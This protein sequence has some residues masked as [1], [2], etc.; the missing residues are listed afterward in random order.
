MTIEE[1]S[2]PTKRR[3]NRAVVQPI[4]LQERDLDMLLS[5]SIGRYLP[6]P[7]IEWLH[8][9][10]WRG[11]Y[12]AYL[13]Q[14]ETDAAATF[15]PTPKLYK[16]LRAMREGSMP[17]VNRLVRSVERATVVFNRLPDAYALTEA[18][19]EL[20]CMRRGYEMDELWYEDPRKRS[21][22]NFEH[23]VA[24]GT[25]Y[26]ALRSTLEFFGQELTDWRGDHLLASRDPNGKGPNYDRVR[27]SWRGKGGRLNIEELPVLPDGT[28]TLAGQRYFVEVDRGTTNLDSWGQKVHAYEAYRRSAKL[29]ARYGTDAFTVLVVAPSDR[30]ITRIAEQIIKVIERPSPTYLFITEE[31]VHPATIRPGW[32]ELTSVEWT[33]RKVVDRLVD[34][35]EQLRFTAHPLWRNP[36]K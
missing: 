21:I 34:L 23:S 4:R 26:A 33:R 1:Q 10:A 19:A 24:I 32:R 18:G 15:Y 31:R 16:R 9:P 20:L 13:D 17:L 8:Y 36:D 29:Q 27:T 6:V 3:R 14:R 5:I 7:A 30:R 22:K 11:R 25:F 35:P 2:Q 12:K 28:F